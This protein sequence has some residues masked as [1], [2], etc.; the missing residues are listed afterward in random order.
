MTIGIVGA[1]QLGP[2]LALAGYPLGLDFLFLDRSAATPAGRFAPVLIGEF[3][4]P[5]LLRRLAERSDVIS[6]DWENISVEALRAAP[7]AARARIAPPLQALAA[8]Q[9]RLSEKRTFQRLRHSHHA[10]LRRWTPRRAGARHCDA[11]ACPACSRRAAS[12]TTARAR[13]AAHAATD[14]R[15]RLGTARQRAAALRGIRAVRVRGID[16]RCARPGR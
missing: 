6:F 13:R 9:D 10:F 14:R 7:R 8:A 15:A 12:A 11:S 4:D 3:D 16:H 5:A 1:G 2:M